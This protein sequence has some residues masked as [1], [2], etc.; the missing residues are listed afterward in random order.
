MQNHEDW[1]YVITADRVALGLSEL[2]GRVY[3]RKKDCVLLDYF[4][5]EFSRFST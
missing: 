1:D 5:S 2:G 4:Q 3:R